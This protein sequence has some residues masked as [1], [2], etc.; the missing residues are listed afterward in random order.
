MIHN[1][2]ISQKEQY[3]SYAA[4]PKTNFIPAALDSGICHISPLELIPYIQ[5]PSEIT[6]HWLTDLILNRLPVIM[7]EFKI[8]SLLTYQNVI[9]QCTELSISLCVVG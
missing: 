3:V 8:C 1:I 6:T 9:Q 5:I 4:P 2:Q 7:L